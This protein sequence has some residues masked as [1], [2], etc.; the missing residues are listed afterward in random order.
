MQ[1]QKMKQLRYKK[2]LQLQVSAFPDKIAK[3]LHSIQSYIS[4]IK[5][6]VTANML[7]LNDNKTALMLVT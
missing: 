2:K 4:N 6:W 7:N 1:T 5:A 3:L